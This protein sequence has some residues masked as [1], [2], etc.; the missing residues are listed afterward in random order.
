MLNL[1]YE[2]KLE[3]LELLELQEKFDNENSREKYFT[4]SG[5]LSR[6]QYPKHLQFFAAGKNYKYRLFMA[7][8]RVGK[9]FAAAYELTCHLTGEYPYWWEGKRFQYP[10]NWWVCGVDSS[11]IQSSLQPTLLGQVGAFG[12]G[13][14]PYDCIDH[15]TLKEAKK[16]DTGIQVFKVK[17]KNGGFSSVEFK[18]YESGRKSF[19]AVAANIWLDEEPPLD[20]FT[21]CLLRTANTGKEPFSLMMT[22]TPLLGMSET[23]LTFLEGK[24]YIEGEVGSG[25]H[26]TVATW[27]DVPHL[28]ED[29][30]RIMEASIP[31][32]QRDARMKGVPS[33]GSGAIY[34]IPLSDITVKRF[35]IPK[36]WKRYGGMDVGSKTAAV[37]CAIDPSTNIHYAYHE[38]YREGELP[39]VHVQ[40]IALPGQYI[41][42]AIDSAAHGRSQIDGN[43]LFD[44]YKD[45][46]LNIHNANKA[47]E[48]G[49]FTC[50]ERLST[51]RLK[52]FDDLNHFIDE[53]RLYRRDDKGRIIKKNDHVMD[54][55]RYSQMTGPDLAINEMEAKPRQIDTYQVSPQ[56]RVQPIL[57]R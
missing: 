47:V 40:G 27:D 6:Q 56:Y 10:N 26:V 39:S 19:Q 52:I 4:D 55:F 54:A 23:I 48:S 33:L 1:T 24:P 9:S 30:K 18:S 37:W 28:S 2:E 13:M 50:W 43:N 57:R 12:T 5:E 41:P 35:E 14:I 15:E 11:L 32:Y 8:N 25:K 38:Y 22:F 45:L 29:D 3:L 36:H 21:E 44:M 31:P 49:L 7:A 51:G 46:G 34:P 53:Y 16:A 17:H 42:I 20:I